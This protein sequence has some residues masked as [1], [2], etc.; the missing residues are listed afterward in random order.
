MQDRCLFPERPFCRDCNHWA[1]GIVEYLR[2]VI[3]SVRSYNVIALGHPRRE[4]PNLQLDLR[5]KRGRIEC[6]RIVNL[7]YMRII[8]ND[9]LDAIHRRR[10][11][12]NERTKRFANVSRRLL[13]EFK[14]ESVLLIP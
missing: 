4:R 10:D 2:E 5:Y 12:L 14:I 7:N 1:I 11:L 13:I 3:G 8:G 6:G 9:A